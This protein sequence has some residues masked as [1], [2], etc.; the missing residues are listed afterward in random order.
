MFW[1]SIEMLHGRHSSV[2][3]WFLFVKKFIL[4]HCLAE[5]IL[6]FWTIRFRRN[7]SFIAWVYQAFY[8]FLFLRKIHEP[9]S[10]TI[11]NFTVTVKHLLNNNFHKDET[12]R[13]QN[14][15]SQQNF[16]ANRINKIPSTILQMGFSKVSIAH[17][18]FT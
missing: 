17:L 6:Y 9:K 15:C 2:S 14:L 13:I 18:Q 4:S 5:R 12:R 11:S 10:T 16:L 8:Q 3:L 1:N 7:F